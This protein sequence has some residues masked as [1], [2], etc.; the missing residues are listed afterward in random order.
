MTVEAWTEVEKPSTGMADKQHR[1]QHSERMSE[2]E[3]HAVNL[4]NAIKDGKLV[5]N[6]VNRKKE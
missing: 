6:Q 5:R 4:V 2:V 3:L 1:S